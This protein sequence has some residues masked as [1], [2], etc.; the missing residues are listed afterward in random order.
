M[1]YFTKL[2]SQ[3]HQLE[4]HFPQAEAQAASVSASPVG[5]HIDHSLRGMIALA[6]QM[7]GSDP[8][9]FRPTFSVGKAVVVGLGFIPKGKAKS[10]KEIDR[11]VQPSEFSLAELVNKAREKTALLKDLP[12]RSYFDHPLFGHLGGQRAIKFITIHTGHHLKIIQDIL[13]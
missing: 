5:W 11:R 6:H 2:Q 4:A 7:K 13:R 8:A 10:P 9:S 3:I 12:E 1:S